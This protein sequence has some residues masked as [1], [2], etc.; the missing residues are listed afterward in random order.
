MK[1][2]PITDLLMQIEQ[3]Y[4]VNLS[5]SLTELQDISISGKLDTS[6][7]VGIFLHNLSQIAPIKVDKKGNDYI[8]TYD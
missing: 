6:V 5:Y 1:E 2:K 7:P 3:L 8:I 4:N